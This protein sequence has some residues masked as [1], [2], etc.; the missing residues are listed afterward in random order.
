[1]IDLEPLGVAPS[2]DVVARM[3]AALV[4]YDGVRVG[5]CRSDQVESL[6]AVAAALDCT[7]VEGHTGPPPPEYVAA[8][9]VAAAVS[10][11]EAC[12]AVSPRAATVLVDVLRRSSDLAVEDALVVESLAYSMLLAGS[13]FAGWLAARASKP[14]TPDPADTVAVSRQDATLHLALNRPQRH[15]AFN[16][17]MRDELCDALDI[18]VL[19]DSIALVR[20]TGNG[21]SF[22]SGGDL[23]EFG[24]APDPV[25]AHLIR[26]QR[27]AGRRLH[28]LRDR[29]VADVHGQCIGAGVEL[30]A[31]AGRVVAHSDAVF[32]LPEVSMGLIPGAGGTVSLPRRI[33][34][35][36]T[37]WMAL[38][39]QRIDAT[40]ALSWGLVDEVRSEV[41]APTPFGGSGAV[42]HTNVG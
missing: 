42:L 15:N 18:A 3:V 26:M 13:E 35:W 24:T 19:D 8:N 34:R 39:G 20:L 1:V 27:S 30:P 7:I 40:T 37:A 5:H 23:D 36:R 41:D 17:V 22:C 28:S 2:A 32:C 16:R 21:R 4:A 14:R 10:A 33:G 31:F 12:V 38:T 6:R 9:E 29:V 11:I 25:T